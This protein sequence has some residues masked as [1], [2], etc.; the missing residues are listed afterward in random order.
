M[1]TLLVS[2]PTEMGQRANATEDRLT[3][4]LTPAYHYTQQKPTRGQAGIPIRPG[5]TS[6]A[7]CALY[8]ATEITPNAMH[9]GCATLHTSGRTTCSALEPNPDL[10]F[11][12]AQ[13]AADD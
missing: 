1:C 10:P 2:G 11:S 5:K 6:K 8:E 3:T 9:P 4:L 7:L 12:D 13:C